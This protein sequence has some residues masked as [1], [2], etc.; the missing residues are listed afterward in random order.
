[1]PTCTDA[2]FNGEDVIFSLNAAKDA[3]MTFIADE[4][5]TLKETSIN[6]VVA[7]IKIAEKSNPTSLNEIPT[8]GDTTHKIVRN[9][10]VVII[11]NGVC[12]NLLGQIIDKQL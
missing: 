12:Y 9:G 7:S 1:M 10:Q 5:I 3:A 2:A 4:S 11:K 6:G 8:I